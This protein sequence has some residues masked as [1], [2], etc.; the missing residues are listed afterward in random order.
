MTALGAGDFFGFT[1]DE[2]FGEKGEVMAEGAIFGYLERT[3]VL[4]LRSRSWSQRRD[5]EKMERIEM[6]YMARS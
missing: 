1:G 2:T 3:L 4:I 5:V 6:A